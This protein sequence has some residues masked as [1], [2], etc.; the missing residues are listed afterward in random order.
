MGHTHLDGKFSLSTVNY[1]V[2][3]IVLRPLYGLV[4]N[5]MSFCIIHRLLISQSEL[6]K[7]KHGLTAI[8]I[9]VT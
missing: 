7:K 8:T 1:H 5:K 2:I 4:D 6:A 9:I 3:C